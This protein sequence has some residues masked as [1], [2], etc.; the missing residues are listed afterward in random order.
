MCEKWGA[1]QPLVRCAGGAKRRRSGLL[2]TAVGIGAH[3]SSRTFVP[4]SAG[5][6]FALRAARF[7]FPKTCFEQFDG[8]LFVAARAFQRQGAEGQ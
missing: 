6:R 4:A 1:G 2:R 7:V 8:R 5:L 3:A